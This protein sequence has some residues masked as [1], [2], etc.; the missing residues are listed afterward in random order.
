FSTHIQFHRLQARYRRHAGGWDLLIQNATGFNGIA[1]ALGR[2]VSLSVNTVNSDFRG[3][4]RREFGKRLALLLGFDVQLAYVWLDAAVPAPVREGEFQ[5][6]PGAL[7]QVVAQE[8]GLLVNPGLYAEA[9]Y[10][11][12][13]RLMLVPGVRF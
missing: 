5:R 11:A 10:Q 9:R 1:L 3:E 8:Q 7:M 6:P 2:S 4:A 13:P 12:H